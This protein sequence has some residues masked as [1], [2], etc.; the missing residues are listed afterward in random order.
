MKYKRRKHATASHNIFS[1]LSYIIII[2]AKNKKAK[3]ANFQTQAEILMEAEQTEK[4]RDDDDEEDEEFNLYGDDG[5]EIDVMQLILA[6]I[7]F[8]EMIDYRE[9]KIATRSISNLYGTS[10]DLSV[11]SRVTKRVC[12]KLETMN[13]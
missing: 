13:C 12:R 2:P 3:K 7:I 6:R 4:E 10:D 9:K 5:V 1:N 8:P 11:R